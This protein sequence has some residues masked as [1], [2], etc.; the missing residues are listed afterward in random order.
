MAEEGLYAAL[1]ARGMSRRAFLQFTSAMAAALALP[2]SYAPRIARAVEAA[3]RIPVIWLRGQACGGN[4]E[5]LLRCAD[6][7]TSNLLLEILAVNYHETL[8][9]ASGDDAT[10]ALQG[11]MERF[12]NGYLAV[13]EGSV[14]RKDGGAACLVG[15][16]PFA[17]VAREVCD[18]ALATIALGSC[19]FD[20]GAPAANGGATDAEGIRSVTGD[21]KVIMLPGCPVNAA[22]LAATIVHYVT[23][24]DFP[25]QDMMGRPLAFYGSLI[26]NECERR[27]HFEFGEFALAWGDEGAQKGW[28]LYKV[29]CKGP[30][31]MGN[32]PQVRYGDGVSW[33]IRAGHG[34][35][36]CFM[37]NFW[38]GYGPAYKRLGSPVPFMPNLTVDAVGVLAVGGIG[39]VAVAHGT[40]M[41]ARS[42]YRR[43]KAR[44]EAE[45][46]ERPDARAAQSAGTAVAVAPDGPGAP[47][48]P[49]EPEAALEPLEPVEPV[50][51]D[52][53]G[54]NGEGR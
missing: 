47:E 22:N 5:A 20:G 49:V 44:R 46:A 35:V 12:P 26:H 1:V 31:T 37:P 34:C 41:A 24:G 39:A 3:P 38:D 7:T 4:S 15:G 32:C 19:A 14:P 54:G 28:C 33:N 30:E 42:S 8:M 9:T 36:G 17:D 43:R 50:Q 27:P 29:G 2:L 25:P 6:P 13:V 21:S 53:P 18:G 51:P 10:L 48:T 40:G 11:A 23:F 45:A 52:E 16:R